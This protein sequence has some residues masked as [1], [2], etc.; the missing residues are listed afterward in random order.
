[1][2]EMQR[3]LTACCKQLRLSAMLA[4]R[5]MAQD[6]NGNRE[7]LLHL[8]RDEIDRRQQGLYI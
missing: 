5:A 6:D 1:M 7:F 8:L 4:E 2:D 3:E